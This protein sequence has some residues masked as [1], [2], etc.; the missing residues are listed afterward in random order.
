MPSLSA[1]DLQ[2]LLDQAPHVRALARALS[3]EDADDVEQL[4]WLARGER[5]RRRR[6]VAGSSAATVP[7]AA[8]LAEREE[9]R[10]VLVDAVNAL[11]DELREVIVLRYF[12][13]EPPRRIATQLNV[14]VET[15]WNRHSRALRLLRERLDARG[16]D[17]RALFVPIASGATPLLSGVLAMSMK[18]I[19]VAVST[20][21]VVLAIVWWPNAPRPAPTPATDAPGAPATLS[22]A[23]P[24]VKDQVEPP[25]RVEAGPRLSIAGR[26]ALGGLRVRVVRAGGELPAAGVTVSL[27][28]SG[29]DSRVGLRRS[30][31]D[32]DGL[33]SFPELRPGGVVVFGDRFG[34]GRR[35]TI[36]AGEIAELEMSLPQGMRLQGVVVASDGTPVEGAA[37]ECAMPAL[38]GRDPAVLARTGSGGRFTIFD[39]PRPCMIGARAAGHAASFMQLLYPESGT[40][41]EVRIQLGGPGGVVAGRVVDPKGK[42]LANV[43]VVV[44]NG[45]LQGLNS[46]AFDRRPLPALVHTDA[47]GRFVAVGLDEGEHPV[48]ARHPDFA[49]WRGGCYVVDYTTS[50]LR[51]HLV[52]GATLRGVVRDGAGAAVHE[53]D[54]AIG[55]WG[56]IEHYRA[57][58]AADGTFALRGLPAG[59]LTVAAEHDELGETT[60]VV[61]VATGAVT[62]CELVLSTGLVLSGRVVDA[63]GEPVANVAI[64]LNADA[65]RDHAHWHAFVR[66]DAAGVFTVPNCPQERPV[67]GRSQTSTIAPVSWPE[68][69][70]RRSP[71]EL[72][73]QRVGPP[74]SR[75]VGVVVGPDRRPIAGARVSA[76]RADVSFYVSEDART[77]PS[78]RF[79]IGPLAAGSWELIVR[80]E[81]WPGLEVPAQT[82]AAETTWDAGLVELTL[83]GS[84]RIRVVGDL[85]PRLMVFDTRSN[86]RWMLRGDR[87]PVT[88][89]ALTPGVYRLLVWGGGAAAAARPL[90]IRAGEVT[91]IEMPTS[92]GVSQRFEFAVPPGAV[93]RGATLYVHQNGERLVEEWVPAKVG[94]PWE[95]ELSFAPGAYE[96]TASARQL[97][98]RYTLTVGS[99]AA[100]PVHLQL[101]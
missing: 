23:A 94:E 83:G 86:G 73:V 71:I 56:E 62:D 58:S 24:A 77:D 37:V 16:V 84:A 66:T 45:P 4:T 46:M 7:S 35:A 34:S 100:A 76:R 97:R 68:I 9:R 18:P 88:T 21:A 61:R 6:E 85:K 59:E 30:R 54:V 28:R 91:D 78:G 82:I 81:R 47:D 14:A 79:D 1:T 96:I 65:T 75:I 13:G 95:A 67:R 43:L 20:V 60:R 101:R 98:A 8:E 15:V 2:R 69:D 27:Y 3:G 99:L 36:M 53:V 5:R 64:E 41:A 57:Q 87:D 22:A 17:R 70:P 48:S 29:A 93:A 19:T 11:P 25:A 90:E 52:A 63:A 31:T 74:T 44:G 39:A 51:I 50:E 89:P 49:P 38:L 40:T 92:Q 32:D 12:E 80:A 72:R 26:D 10:R 42:P 33:A 55:A